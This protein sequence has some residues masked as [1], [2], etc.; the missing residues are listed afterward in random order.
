ME[1][2]GEPAAAPS[3]GA[4]SEGGLTIKIVSDHWRQILTLVRQ[5]NPTTQGLLNSGKLLGVKDGTLFLG[6]SEVLKFKMEKSEN[7]EIVCQVLKQVLGMDV[8]V[9]CV[10]MKGRGPSLPPDVDSDGMVAA[11]LRDLGGE[12]V[13]I[14]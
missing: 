2:E 11:A 1:K 8:P 10:V 9:R 14:Q 3:E 5:R 13:D 4:S 6:Y 12:I 7:I